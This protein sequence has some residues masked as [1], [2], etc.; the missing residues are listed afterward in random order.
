MQK[1]SDDIFDKV[2][3]L[4]PD[5]DSVGGIAS[6]LQA[7][8]KTIRPFHYLSTNDRRG[9]VWC[10]VRLAALMAALPFERMRGRRIAHIH[11]AAGRSWSRKVL[12]MNW[13]SLLGFRIVMHSH[14]GWMR[15]MVSRKGNSLARVLRRA[16]ANVTLTEGWRRFFVE[17]MGLDTR[18]INN[19]VEPWEVAPI[20]A[21][22]P[23]TFYIAAKLVPAKGIAELMQAVAAVKASGRCFRLIVAGDG[24]MR[25]EM[26]R[27]RDELRIADVVD[28]RGSVDRDGVRAIIDR[29]HVLVLPSY[30]EGMPITILEAFIAGR[31]VIV[32]PVGGIPELVDDGR[33][34]L[35]VPPRDADALAAAMMRLIDNPD[36]VATLG[37]QGRADVEPFMPDRVVESLA[38]LYSDVLRPAKP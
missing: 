9:R 23:M 14:S 29:S 5:I 18:V 20:P 15:D 27:M 12:V 13:A 1:S 17:T 26:L 34:G 16:D 24:P 37:A 11:Y 7:Y 10:V 33:N 3:Y 4:A 21:G 6:V 19:I 36:L 31:P 35:I 28:Y 8:R 30:T 22:S 2:L 32:T 38:A 25:D